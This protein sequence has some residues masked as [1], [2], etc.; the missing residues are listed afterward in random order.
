MRE[1]AGGEGG[2]GIK[3][4]LNGTAVFI[5]GVL[6]RTSVGFWTLKISRDVW[7]YLEMVHRQHQ[8]ISLSYQVSGNG[9]GLS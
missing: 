7:H 5:G 6:N 4:C 9:R 3:Y 2:T 8:V 1:T